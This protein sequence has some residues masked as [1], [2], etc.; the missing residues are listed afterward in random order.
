[1]TGRESAAG[2][3]RFHLL[4]VWTL[5]I[6]GLLLQ[7]LPLRTPRAWKLPYGEPQP[8]LS[9]NGRLLAFVAE[10]GAIA[11]GRVFQRRDEVPAPQRLTDVWVRDLATGKSLRVGGNGSSHSPSLSADGRQLLFLSEATDLVPDDHNAV[12]DLFLCD[13]SN[14]ALTRLEPSARAGSGSCLAP[15]LAGSGRMAAF[16]RYGETGE[17]RR[18]LVLLDVPTGQAN[19]VDLGVMG[20]AF[21]AAVFAEERPY[22]AFTVAMS[23]YGSG[24]RQLSSQV[25]GASIAAGQLT[26][27]GLLSLAPAGL[28]DG[29]SFSPTLGGEGCAFI[30]AATN[31]IPKDDNGC[32]DVYYR[33][34]PS[35]PLQRVA[36]RGVEPDGDSFEPVLSADGRYLAFTSYAT[37]LVAGDTNGESDVFL[38]DRRKG[39]VE[40]I[41]RSGDGPSFAP[42]LSGDGS[43]LVFASLAT[44]LGGP[45][46]SLYLWERATGKVA[47]LR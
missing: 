24:G 32:Q 38:W 39:T 25:V 47:L 21:E 7:A 30:S 20:P 12:Q 37:N 1:M 2:L 9:R 40:P 28:P 31:L 27:R 46:G 16:N 22:V 35:G 17:R 44:D 45:A 14:H 34:L 18:E 41:S 26:G 3:S 13:T 42:T 15:T 6:G 43:R 4:V 33:D 23:G 19:S 5:V 36:P 29:P 11:E 8:R 10:R